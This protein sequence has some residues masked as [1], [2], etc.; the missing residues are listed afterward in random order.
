MNIPPRIHSS[1][2]EVRFPRGVN[3]IPRGKFMLFKT[4]LAVTGV[5]IQ[6]AEK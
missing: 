2:L 1:P 3:Y 5:S 6:T 4:G